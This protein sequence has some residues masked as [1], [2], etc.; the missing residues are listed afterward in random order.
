MQPAMKSRLREIL[1]SMHLDETAEPVMKRYFKVSRYNEI[2]PAA[3]AELKRIRD[4]VRLR[5]GG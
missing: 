5:H 4:A 2:D 3:E 1:L